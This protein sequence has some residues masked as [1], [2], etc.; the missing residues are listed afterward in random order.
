[1]VAQSFSS[2]RMLVLTTILGFL[3]LLTLPTVL[4]ARGALQALPSLYS[5]GTLAI[6]GILGGRS[7]PSSESSLSSEQLQILHASRDEERIADIAALR[8][9]FDAIVYWNRAFCGEA[10]R[11]TYRST[12]PSG[13]GSAWFPIDLSLSGMDRLTVTHPPRDPVNTSQYRYEFA[14]GPDGAYELN[15]RF[16]Y[17]G[18]FARASH[19]GGNNDSRYEIGTDLRLIP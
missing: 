16:E 17:Q 1:W 13:G 10:A 11:K 4:A 7:R 6:Q 2:P 3:F 14:C 9:V 5:S 8:E 19:D 18:S 12:S 15:A